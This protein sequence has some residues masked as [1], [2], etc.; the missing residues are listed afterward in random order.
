M[1]KKREQWYRELNSITGYHLGDDYIGGL[2]VG[3]PVIVFDTI[4]QKTGKYCFK[5]SCKDNTALIHSDRARELVSKL[6]AEEN[7]VSNF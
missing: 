5:M 6:L 1:N 7:Q 3:F 4:L 2:N